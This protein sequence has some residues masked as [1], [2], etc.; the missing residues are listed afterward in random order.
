MEHSLNIV[1]LIEKTPIIR[2]SN[3]YQSKLLNKIKEQ[4]IDNEQQVFVASFY[5]YLNYNSTK[6]FV[7]NLDDVWKWTGFSRKDPA[8][9]VLKKHFIE[10]VDYKIVENIEAPATSGASNIRGCAGQNKENITM[11]INTFK[12]FCLKANTKKSHEIHKYY[13]K[14]EEILFEVVNE[15]TAELRLQLERKDELLKKSSTEIEKLNNILHKRNKPQII[16]NEK[17]VVYLLVAYIN[18]KTIYIIGMTAD[19]NKRY[20]TYKLK[21]IL[22]PEQDIKL[23]YYKCCRN[24]NIL[25]TVESCVI[26]KFSENLIEGKKEIFEFDDTKT[27]EEIINNFKDVIDFYVNSFASVSSNI[28]IK[29][30]KNEEEKKEDTRIRTELYTEANRNEINE[31]VRIDRQENPE[32]YAEREKRRDP[33]KKKAKNKRY[34]ENHKEEIAVKTAEYRENNK[35]KITERTKEYYEEH[36]DER[37]EYL[38]NYRQENKD[39]IKKQKTQKIKCCICLTELTKQCWKVHSTSQKHSAL[40]NL[41]PERQNIYEIIDTEN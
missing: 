39:K 36:K 24:I 13:I 33:D 27:E 22:I 2:L 26:L 17:F 21:G 14:L 3:D 16:T 30:V 31:K 6:D 15:E 4:F 7:I 41:Y 8:K 32:K 12:S 25:R 9:V 34:Y 28:V 11:T 20:R 23:V 38:K 35:E 40:S 1:N 29:E 18:G 10:N 5:C 19:I 37:L